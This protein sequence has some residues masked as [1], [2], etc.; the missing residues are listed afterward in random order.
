M[1]GAAAQTSTALNQAPKPL[2]NTLRSLTFEDNKVYTIVATGDGKFSATVTNQGNTVAL[3]MFEESTAATTFGMGSIRWFHAIKTQASSPISIYRGDTSDSLRLASGIAF[4]SLSDYVD[5]APATAQAFPITIQT[6]AQTVIA[7]TT[8]GRSEVSHD[9]RA[10]LRATIICAVNDET[11]STVFCRMI[12]SRVVAYVRLINDLASQSDLVQGAFGSQALKD[13][14]LTLW[15][16]YEVPRPEQTVELGQKVG[17]SLVPRSPAQTRGLYGVVSTVSSG[18]CSGYG[19]TWIPLIIMDYAVRHTIV[20]DNLDVNAY[21]A[22]VNLAA[23]NSLGVNNQKNPALDT[24]PGFSQWFWGAPFFK[25]AHFLVKTESGATLT[26]ESN[27]VPARADAVAWATSALL[28]DEYMEPGQYYTLIATGPST[29]LTTAVT[30]TPNTFA[31]GASLRYFWRLDRTIESVASGSSLAAG[32]AN[33]NFVPFGNQNLR[34]TINFR[35]K[36]ATN[37]NLTPTIAA[38]DSY[39]VAASV[40]STALVAFTWNAPAA[41]LIADAGD[42]TF[43]HTVDTNVLNNPNNDVCL[44]KLPGSTDVTLVSGDTIDIYLLNSYGCKINNNDANRL[45]V[46]VCKTQSALLTGHA[47]MTLLDGSAAPS[48]SPFFAG[49]ASATTSSVALLSAAL[50]AIIAA[51]F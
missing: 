11:T 37:I 28:L 20:R 4:G 6:T 38:T 31:T 46:S 33:V 14:K 41:P 22:G 48:P 45:V 8:A 27:N 21:Y 1:L 47:V 2:T 10:G 3:S 42:Y 35:R 29:P 39:A 15:G 18:T 9:I 26:G 49:S 16:S 19:E 24:A 17:V 50:L 51:L 43:D 40:A 12:P 34:G 7:P 23:Y 44:N 13:V 25:R 32:K 5:V 30:A 36:G